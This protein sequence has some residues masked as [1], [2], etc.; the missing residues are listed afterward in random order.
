MFW[1]KLFILLVGPLVLLYIFNKIVRKHLNVEKPKMFSYNHV[2]QN[3][4]QLDWTIRIVF[5]VAMLISPFITY[6]S[7]D[8]SRFA[9]PVLVLIYIVISEIARAYMEWKYAANP[10]AYIA[11]ISQLIFLLIWFIPVYYI[12]FVDIIRY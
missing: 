6:I 7:E 9:A 10:K 3:H 12:L 11:T 8:I 1:L 5:I 2:N 4:K